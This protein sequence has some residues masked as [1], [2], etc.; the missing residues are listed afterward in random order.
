[1]AAADYYKTET[2]WVKFPVDGDLPHKENVKKL[3][4]HIR[5]LLNQKWAIESIDIVVSETPPHDSEFSVCL[6]RTKLDI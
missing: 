6:S 3:M 4:D 5:P 2:E 1:M